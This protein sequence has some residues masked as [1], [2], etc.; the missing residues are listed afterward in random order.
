M[1]YDYKTVYDKIYEVGY[2]SDANFCHARFLADFILPKIEFNT[3]LDLGSSKGAGIDH[4][5]KHGKFCMGIEITDIGVRDA[6]NLHRPT[7]SG[8]ICKLPFPDK[9]FDLVVSTDVMEHIF[10]KDVSSIVDECHRVS[11]KYIAHKIALGPEAG[12]HFT[13]NAGLGEIPLHVTLLSIQKWIELFCKDT[14]K[15]ICQQGNMFLI[16]I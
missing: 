10:E 1:E 13:A 6:I 14:G 4:Y 2:H 5:Q 9:S 3:V 16:E 8:S 7:V 11:K 15:L 12:K